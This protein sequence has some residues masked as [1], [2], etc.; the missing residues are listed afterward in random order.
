MLV[1]NTCHVVNLQSVR[2]A[3]ILR[4]SRGIRWAYGCAPIGWIATAGGNLATFTLSR[5]CTA[6][7]V[8]WNLPEHSGTAGFGK[9]W[10]KIA[11]DSNIGE[12]LADLGKHNHQISKE[13]M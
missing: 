6:P 13:K 2:N 4:T 5:S 1:L 12:E 7:C 10:I 3:N 9:R 8:C 11:E